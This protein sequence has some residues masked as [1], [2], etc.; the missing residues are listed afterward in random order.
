MQAKNWFIFNRDSELKFEVAL[1]SQLREIERLTSH[2]YKIYSSLLSYKF[3]VKFWL[4]F[5]G[6]A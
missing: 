5:L 2:K 6:S 3:Q 1:I 4:F